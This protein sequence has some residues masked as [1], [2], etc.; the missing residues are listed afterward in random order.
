MKCHRCKYDSN[1]PLILLFSLSL[2]SLLCVHGQYLSLSLYNRERLPLV[3]LSHDLIYNFNDL[4]TSYPKI[5][6]FRS[7]GI[8]D[9]YINVDYAVMLDQYETVVV[10]SVTDVELI[11][12]TLENN[13]RDARWYRVTCKV[14]SVP[15]G[16]FPFE[17]MVF[18]TYV[19]GHC[20]PWKTYAQDQTFHF[21]MRQENGVWEIAQQ[22]R[23]S[24]FAPYRIEDHVSFYKLKYLDKETDYSQW[25]DFVHTNYERARASM[26]KDEIQTVS[27]SI[28]L[29]KFFIIA[30]SRRNIL[31]GREYDYGN[32]A[33]VVYS[34]PDGKLIYNEFDPNMSDFHVVQQN[35][36]LFRMVW[37]VR[38]LEESILRLTKEIEKNPNDIANYL[39][40][41]R[42]FSIIL[43]FD[44]AM[45]DLAKAE[46]LDVTNENIYLAY[47]QIYLQK[48]EAKL[49]TPQ[50]DDVMEANLTKMITLFPSDTSNYY[51]RISLYIEQ[52]KLE[53]AI[54]DLKTLLEINKR[55]LDSRPDN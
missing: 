31:E 8:N 6:A 28:E 47:T 22:V 3:E 33:Y 35:R 40:R 48:R 1:I 19:S 51:T 2:S 4:K 55:Q 25:D 20:Y 46:E 34:W 9:E 27:T 53:A 24:S 41:A 10:A 36:E 44:S 42:K 5:K 21:G 14:R 15:R 50:D 43:E 37:G 49:T 26:H 16:D 23:A 13:A 29:D 54:M 7:L 38:D 39:E 11:A 32:L 17:T 45:A 12:L 18:I 52:D 30:F